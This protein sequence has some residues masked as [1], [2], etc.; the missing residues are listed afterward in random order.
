VRVWAKTRKGTRQGLTYRRPAASLTLMQRPIPFLLGATLLA[1]CG[2]SSA[3]KARASIP[4]DLG[5]LVTQEQIAASGAK[6]AWDALR[7][8]VPSIQL[9]ETRGR[10][11]RIQRRGRTSIYL[12]DQVRVIVDNVRVAD[13][14][15]LQQI[16]AAEIFK[17]QVLNA[18]DATTYYGGASASG[19]VIITTRAQ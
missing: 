6:T 2:T 3:H 5:T 7:L 14:Q 19:V 16:A 11:A 12:D 8:A 4:P 1:G 10:A 15:M 17:I 13:L 9:R 18:M